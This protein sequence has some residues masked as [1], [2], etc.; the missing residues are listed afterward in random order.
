M[1]SPGS[2]IN[3]EQLRPN[4]TVD[5][6]GLTSTEFHTRVNF[7]SRLVLTFFQPSDLASS[8]FSL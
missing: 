1:G 3:L 6:L 7:D 2:L 4:V 5:V 8:M